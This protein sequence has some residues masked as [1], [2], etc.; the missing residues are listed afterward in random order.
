MFVR[1]LQRIRCAGGI[2]VRD[3]SGAG[4]QGWDV[5]RID[6]EA[7]WGEIAAVFGEA[8]HVLDI[9][10]TRTDRGAQFEWF[11]ALDHQVHRAL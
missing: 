1:T 9:D 7:G 4:A 3:G 10:L 6:G 5:V 2:E 11:V 8:G